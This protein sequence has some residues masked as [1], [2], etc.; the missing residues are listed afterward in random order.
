MF[1]NSQIT[2]RITLLRVNIT[3]CLKLSAIIIQE[4]KKI[5]IY[6]HHLLPTSRRFFQSETPSDKHIPS[7]IAPEKSATLASPAYALC[8][9]MRAHTCMHAMHA[10][11]CAFLVFV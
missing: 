3:I 6:T 11:S 10:G 2:A 8:T 9:R 5:C 7:Y 4:Y 1:L